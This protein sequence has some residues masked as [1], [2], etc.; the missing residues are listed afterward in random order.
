MKERIKVSSLI[1]RASTSLNAIPGNEKYP[2]LK[3]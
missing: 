3:T 2:N 1:Y